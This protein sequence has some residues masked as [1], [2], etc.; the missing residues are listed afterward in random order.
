MRAIE[1][2]KNNADKG[3]HRRCI[4]SN[5]EAPRPNIADDRPMFPCKTGTGSAFVQVQGGAD[6]SQSNPCCYNPC[7]FPAGL[8]PTLGAGLPVAAAAHGLERAQEA[9][10]ARPAC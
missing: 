6:R 2:R 8:L 4:G 5:A 7:C 10:R 1:C 9:I 3:T